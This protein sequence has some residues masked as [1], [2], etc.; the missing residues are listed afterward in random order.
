[1]RRIF[2]NQTAA[3][4]TASFLLMGTASAAD[5]Q[6]NPSEAYFAGWTF[7][8]SDNPRGCGSANVLAGTSSIT[9]TLGPLTY[10]IHAVGATQ[11][12]ANIETNWVDCRWTTFGGNLPAG[13]NPPASVDT[14]HV[15]AGTFLHTFNAPLPSGS[16]LFFQ[17][18]DGLEQTDITFR[19]C[20]G[21]AIDASAFDWLRVSAPS[22]SVVIPSHTAGPTWR[23]LG[24]SGGSSNETSAIAMRSSE[25]C[26]IETVNTKPGAAGAAGGR[27][28]FFAAPPV[29]DLSVNIST[30]GGPGSGFSGNYEVTLACTKDGIDVTPQVLP[31]SPV[32]VAGGTATPAALNFQQIPVGAICTA[33]QVQPASPSGYSWNGAPPPQTVTTIAGA[34]ANNVT[35]QNELLAAVV[36]PQPSP[37]QPVPAL[38]QW[39]LLFTAFGLGLFALVWARKRHN[40]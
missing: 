35:W 26:Q 3:A 20:A 4:V 37:V 29:V 2:L 33:S 40:G 15:R 22:A 5:L 18:F 1:M 30:T 6:V 23:I 27:H 38:S 17:D 11:T 24:T 10:E 39:G 7:N 19:N 16:L 9:G 8:V 34:G 21:Q 36:P 13:N 14:S 31:A 32:T 28:F 25:V 12:M